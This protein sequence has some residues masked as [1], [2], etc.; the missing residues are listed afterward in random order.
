MGKTDSRDLIWDV[1]RGI[2][3]LMVIFHHYTRRYDILFGHV[4]PWPIQLDFSLGAWGV[5]VFFI[6]TGF[7]IIPSLSNSSSIGA[8]YRKRIVR[9]YSSYIPCVIITWFLM[10]IAP[11][12]G[13]R[14]VNFFSFIGNL[15]MF[16]TFLGIPN[17]DGAYW[18]LAVQLIFY[19]VS[20]IFFSC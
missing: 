10:S 9:L 5:C 11:P 3:A 1:F 4:E 20:A 17:V 19:I 14:N 18:T 13:V 12:M 8:Y 7:F 16:Q 6:L 2:A 15:T